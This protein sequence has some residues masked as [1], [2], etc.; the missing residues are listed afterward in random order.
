MRKDVV[1][2][3]FRLYDY[4]EEVL[5]NDKPEKVRWLVTKSLRSKKFSPWM[6]AE[7]AMLQRVVNTLEGGA[8]TND[9]AL[10]TAI[11]CV[12]DAHVQ[13]WDLGGETE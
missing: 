5:D 11:T 1:A 13:N 12:Y 9:E 2:G 7:K 4:E 8:H 10:D 6:V 3:V